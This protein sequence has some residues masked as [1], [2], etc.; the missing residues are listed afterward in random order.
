MS[1]T[2][3]EAKYLMSLGCIGEA[4]HGT[5]ETYTEICRRLEKKFGRSATT[6]IKLFFSVEEAAKICKVAPRAVHKWIDAGK[7]TR[8]TDGITRESLIGFMKSHGLSADQ[9]P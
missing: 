1:V 3:E 7:L 9:I 4:I 8:T 5:S 6:T 2:E